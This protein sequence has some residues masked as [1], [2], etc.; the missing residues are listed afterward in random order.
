M[1]VL[2]VIPYPAID[3]VLIH[4]GPLA[5]RWYA[6]AYIVGIIGG[7]F[8][9]RAIIASERLWGGPA[10]FSLVDFDDLFDPGDML[11]GRGRVAATVNLA[12]DALGTSGNVA[13]TEYLHAWP[14]GRFS[15]EANR[16]LQGSTARTKAP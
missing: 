16:L 11:A 10:P 13:L 8:Y 3:P 9:A 2:P 5:V 4:I 1:Y 7:W 14:Q 15:R 12:P 6:L